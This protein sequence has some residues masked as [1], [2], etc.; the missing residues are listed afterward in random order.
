MVRSGHVGTWEQIAAETSSHHWSCTKQAKQSTI[1]VLTFALIC[2]AST[3]RCDAARH[4]LAT[5]TTIP[6]EV[7]PS[8]PKLPPIPKSTLPASPSIPT[9][10]NMDC[11]F[12]YRSTL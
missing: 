2:I 3:E 12:L 11:S 6:V 10:P 5:P 9:I 4:L 1:Y 8:L 7:V